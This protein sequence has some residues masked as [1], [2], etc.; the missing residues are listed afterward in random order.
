[1][2][3][4]GEE[5]GGVLAELAPVRP[6]LVLV[7]MRVP[8]PTRPREEGVGQHRPRPVEWVP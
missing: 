8:A 2:N 1:V 7:E 4:D 3:G 6:G 5:A